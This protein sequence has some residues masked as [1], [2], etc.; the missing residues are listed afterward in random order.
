MPSPP[1]K[2]ATAVAA[3]PGQPAQD[4]S[5]IRAIDATSAAALGKLGVT[6]YEQI[7][8]WMRS[9]IERIEQSLGQKGRINQENWIE[10]AQILA[11]G[12]E[13]HYASRRARGETAN[14]E[15]TPDEG[16]RRPLAQAAADRACA[17][18]DHRHPA[19]GNR[20]RRRGGRRD[21]RAQAGRRRAQP[22]PAHSAATRTRH[23]ARRGQP[24][25]VRDSRRQH[26]RGGAEARAA[27]RP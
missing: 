21:R 25:R 8:A 20:R 14:A 15:P 2:P 6:R 1:A 27:L 5:R 17:T 12:G 9:D 16:E 19:S 4:L 11:K 7:A 22:E 13:T 10:Q 3:A 18:G 26:A 23:A 24:G